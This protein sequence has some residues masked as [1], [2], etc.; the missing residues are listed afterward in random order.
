MSQVV[1]DRQVSGPGPSAD[2]NRIN[3]SR[4]RSGFGWTTA[5]F[6]IAAVVATP[7]LFI[8]SSLA[9]PKSDVWGHLVET[10]LAD[11]VV[12]SLL[13]MLCVG[14]GV[15]V[16]GAGTAWLV[17]MCTFPGRRLLS[18][19]LLL[20]LAA[21]AYVLA[22]VYTDLLDYNG[23]LQSTLR[24]VFG[25]STRRDYWFPNVRSLPGAALMLTLALYPYVYLM[26]RAALIQQC[27]CVLEVSRTLGCSPWQAFARVGAPLARPAIAGGTALA[28]METLNDY[29]TVQY[30]GVQTFTTGIYRTWFGLGDRIAA[31]QLGTVLVLFVL[32]LLLVERWSRRA[33][34][35]QHATARYRTLMP[36]V[37]RRGRQWLIAASCLLPVV[38]GFVVPAADLALRALEHFDKVLDARFLDAAGASL[39]LA[40]TTAAIAVVLCLVL[41]YGRRQRPT[42]GL[43]AATTVATMGYAAPGSVIAVGTLIPLT[44][45][46][47]AIDGVARAQFDANLGLVFT[48]GVAALVFAYLVRFLA[49]AYSPVESALGKI[50]P[51]FDGAARTLGHGSVSRLV[52]VHVPMIASGLLTAAILVFVDVMKELPATLIVRPF[53]FDTLAVQTYRLASDERLDEAAGYALAIIAVGLVPVVLLTR[54]L[55]RSRP[56][57]G[58]PN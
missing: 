28:L 14:A 4:L 29:G 11:Y 48:G 58:Q 5:A 6:A 20:P 45:L 34:S 12:N 51:S 3:G 47:K 50:R 35:Y 21:P 10:V 26:T 46:D 42:R 43:G 23:P 13:L 25:W 49:V 17:T 37:P 9:F 18:W 36:L 40:G 2:R 38:L 7:L 56:G 24:A 44:A 30:F 41:A 8:V 53:N 55:T 33:A 1:Y 19:A 27:V 31:A 16:I 52:R 54:L 39:I 22:Y 57:G 15:I 32:A